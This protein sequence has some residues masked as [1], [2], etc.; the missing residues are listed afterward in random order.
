MLYDYDEQAF[1]P[2]GLWRTQFVTVGDDD[3]DEDSDDDIDPLEERGGWLVYDRHRSRSTLSAL[4][5]QLEPG[6]ACRELLDCMGMS[7]LDP[8]R[9]DDLNLTITSM[10]TRSVAEPPRM[11]TTRRCPFAHG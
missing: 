11:L 9:G 10:L 2:R 3:E 1:R 5:K 8:G 6:D 4:V 7:N